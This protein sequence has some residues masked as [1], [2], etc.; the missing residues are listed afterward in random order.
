MSIA[1]VTDLI[2]LLGAWHLLE[3]P[4][5]AELPAL[6]GRCAGAEALAK[7]LV[8]RGWLTAYQVNEIFLGRGDNLLLGSYVLVERLG[9]GGMGAV[10]KARNWKLHKT[11]ALKLIRK[12][13]LAHADAIKRFQREI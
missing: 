4:Q 2:K 6:E 3:S 11:V 5:V 7:E 8:K 13:R 1:S 9:L 10:F 12:E